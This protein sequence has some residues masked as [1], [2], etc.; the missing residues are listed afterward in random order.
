MPDPEQIE[1][2]RHR[3][4]LNDLRLEKVRRQCPLPSAT[5]PPENFLSIRE[6]AASRRDSEFGHHSGRVMARNVADQQ[7]GTWREIDIQCSR[8]IGAEGR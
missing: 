5:C 4:A 6:A 2:D 7:V 8:R 3:D 1:M